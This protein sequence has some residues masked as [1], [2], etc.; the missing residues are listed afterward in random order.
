MAAGVAARGT[1]A[2]QGGIATK[3]PNAAIVPE[4]SRPKAPWMLTAGFSCF[5]AWMNMLLCFEGLLRDQ[6]VYGGGVVHDPFFVGALLAAV[7]ILLAADSRSR[8]P[9]RS[10]RAGSEEAAARRTSPLF[11]ACMVAG[12]LAAAAGVVL[13]GT[14]DQDGQVLR[15]TASLLGILCGPALAL[16]TL[17][18]GR[19]MASLALRSALAAMGFALCAQW[20]LLSLV[21][22]GGLPAKVA[23]AV[24]LPLLSW[25]CL[26][27]SGS[28]DGE[29]GEAPRRAKP[30]E[31]RKPLDPAVCRIAGA[32][33]CFCLVIQFV[34]TC[35]I[36]FGENP[37][38]VGF[39]WMLFLVVFAVVLL[40][41]TASL[42]LMRRWGSYR[43]EFFYRASFLFAVVACAAL[44]VLPT[45]P[46]LPYVGIYAAYALIVLTMWILAWSVVFLKG[47]APDRAFG[48]VFGLQFAAFLAGFCA[49]KVLEWLVGIAAGPALLPW[50]SVA[51]VAVLACAFCFVLPERALMELSPR[52]TRL[53][54]AGLQDRCEALAAQ[55]GLTAREAEVFSYLARGRDVGFI[56]QELFIS[57]NTVNTHRKNLYRKLGVHTQ[58]ELLSLI[59][60]PEGLE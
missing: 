22:V 33:F 21:I 10:G 37:L 45:A 36:G 19:A 2:A 53:N 39:F 58:Q 52:L 55:Y 50:I 31:A 54:R 1:Q 20:P 38:E 3:T 26:A 35:H 15:A 14:S 8:R 48:T 44:G 6:I 13:A 17:R 5:V 57:R 4:P 9:G 30:V 11:G 24:A 42:A 41:V 7:A 51:A 12:A 32:L 46:L 59:E 47:I 29:D 28:L 27:K 18:W 56:E 23:A 43:T 16:L 25:A 34:W 40:V 49:A 60:E